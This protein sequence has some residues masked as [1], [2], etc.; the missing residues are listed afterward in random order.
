MLCH[1]YQRSSLRTEN[2]KQKGPLPLTQLGSIPIVENITL[3]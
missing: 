1:R 3:L 2:G